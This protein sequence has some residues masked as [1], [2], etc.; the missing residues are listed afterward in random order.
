MTTNTPQNSP[1]AKP[2]VGS[3]APSDVSDKITL[4]KDELKSLVEASVED[5]LTQLKLSPD[6]DDPSKGTFNP[7]V[8]DQFSNF[9]KKLEVFGVDVKDILPGFVLRWINDERDRVP[10]SE[11]MGWTFVLRTEV[12]L[13]EKVFPP[14]KDMGD[15]IAVYVGANEGGQPMRAFLMK[16]PQEG[17]DQIMRRK[18]AQD[19]MIEDAI[20]RGAVGPA[21]S[22]G[23]YAGTDKGT[24]KINYQ[25][26]HR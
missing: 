16:I 14:N 12:A 1:Q 17:Y 15:K 21:L 19:D 20:R 11:F 3:A 24:V 9:D 10:R 6:Q 23:G 5:R 13:S 4:S 25:P 7:F 18:H 8:D 26:K 22:R 2:S